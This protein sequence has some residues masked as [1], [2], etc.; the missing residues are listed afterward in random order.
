MSQWF[1][2]ADTIR[3]AVGRGPAAGQRARWPELL[4]AIEDAEP[5]LRQLSDDQLRKSGL[6]LKYRAKSGEPLDTLLVDCYAHTREAGRRTIGLRHYDVQLAAG[7][8][9]QNRCVVEMQTGEGKTL[10]ATLPLCL[11][12]LAGRGA[13]LAT[14]NDYL[15]RRDAEW[16]RPVYTALGLTVGVVDA[17]TPPAQRRRE[18][19]CDITYG[20]AKEFGFDFLRERLQARDADELAIEPLSDVAEASRSGRGAARRPH[21]ILVDEADSILIDEARTP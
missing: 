17:E 10:A 5:A 6:A 21:F 15:A 13:H 4:T 11:F 18:Y 14:A 2:L 7:V 3:H 1:R 9:M 8:A 12:A 20:T 16:M 19:D